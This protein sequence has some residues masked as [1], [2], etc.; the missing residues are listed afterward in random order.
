MNYFKNMWKLET[1]V[2][3]RYLKNESISGPYNF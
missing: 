2:R 3:D 1:E